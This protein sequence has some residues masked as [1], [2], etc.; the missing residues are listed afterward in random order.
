MNNNLKAAAAALKKQSQPVSKGMSAA[1][2]AFNEINQPQ[3]APQAQNNPNSSGT[4]NPVRLN[5]E[6]IQKNIKQ[7]RNSQGM[8]QRELARKSGMSQGTITRAERHGWISL[9][10]LFR[11]V[12]ALNKKLIIN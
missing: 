12:N 9:G 10:C 4:S 3:I 8:T 7:E 5:M 6:E 1:L 2:K 11:I